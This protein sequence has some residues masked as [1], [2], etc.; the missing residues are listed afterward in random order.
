PTERTVTPSRVSPLVLVSGVTSA[1]MS[2]RV[3]AERIANWMLRCWFRAA[4]KSGGA[5]RRFPGV[6]LGKTLV[7]EST[8]HTLIAAGWLASVGTVAIRNAN[9]A[10]QTRARD[11]WVPLVRMNCRI[12]VAELPRRAF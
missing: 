9:R 8:D 7:S 3:F 12:E 10:V 2:F 5:E 6:S 1:E 11:I 4:Q